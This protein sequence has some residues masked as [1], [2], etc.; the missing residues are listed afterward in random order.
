M[1][2]RA[3]GIGRRIGATLL[4]ALVAGVVVG[5]ASR[6]LMAAIAA[7]MGNDLMFSV[8]GT[9]MIVIVFTLFA[10]PAAAT[11]TANRVVRT[12]G[13]WFSTGFVGFASARNGITEAKTIVL[14]SEDRFMLIAAIVAAM[15]AVLVAYGQ[16]AQYAKRRFARGPRETPAAPATPVPDLAAQGR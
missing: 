11:A 13:R 2:V 1:G 16:L 9:M 12:A 6:A 3:R 8:P 7:A 5:L 14:A 10:I 4:A 15:A